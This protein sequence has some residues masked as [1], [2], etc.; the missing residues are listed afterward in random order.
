MRTSITQYY[1][2][3]NTIIVYFYTHYCV[4]GLFARRLDRCLLYS[5]V[6]AF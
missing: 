2:A 4:C 5:V 1:K 6:L 3:Y